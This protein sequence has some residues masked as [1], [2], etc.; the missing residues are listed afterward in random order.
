M[1]FFRLLKI[2][3]VSLRFG[4][5]E[6]ILGHERVRGLRWVFK[7]LLF[8]RRLDAPRAC[9]CAWRWKRWARSS[10]SSARC[11]RR[12]ATCCRRTSPTSSPSC[13][14]RCRRSRPKSC[15]PT[16][17]RA[18]GRP[19]DEVFAAFRTAEPVASASVAQVHFAQP[20]RRPRGRGQ[21][22]AAR[23]SPRSSRH[24]SRCCDAGASWSSCC[25]PT[26]GACARTRS[27]PSSPSTRR[28]ARPHA[29][30]GQREPA[31]PQFRRLAA[32]ARA[33]DV[34][35]LLRDRGDGDAA[36]AR[37]ADLAG[38]GA[39]RAGHRH[40]DSSR[41]PA[42]RSSSRRCSATA[43]S[44]PTCTRATSWCAADGRYVAL[45]FG[46][47][48]TLTEIDK[49][50]LAQNFLAFF[51]RDYR[52]VAA[53]AHRI[54]LGAGRHARRRIRDRDPRGMRAGLRRGR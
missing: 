45:D 6:F 1:R 33:G 43:S 7:F 39:A 11:C 20:A 46:I 50:Y 44:T 52:R 19:V 27:L 31:A 21:G 14:T 12:A 23:H 3:A 8:R 53:G 29:R 37:H 51:R 4:L 54:G 35:G 5:D 18:Y 48:G 38:R 13:R 40:P 42:S 10:S 25:G 2:I 9:A 16:L 47:M 28:R 17:E 41:A 36:H 26:A 30:G 49:N 15:S 24:D 22:A 34:L 32:A